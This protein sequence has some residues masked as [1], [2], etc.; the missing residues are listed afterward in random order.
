MASLD[1]NANTTGVA[2]KRLK[3][4]LPCTRHLNTVGTVRLRTASRELMMFHAGG[5]KANS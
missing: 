5:R 2:E 4:F 1:S 3:M